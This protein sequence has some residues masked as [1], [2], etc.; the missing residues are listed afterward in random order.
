MTS[1][2]LATPDATFKAR[3]RDVKRPFVSPTAKLELVLSIPSSR[4]VTTHERLTQAPGAQPGDPVMLTS[5]M[6]GIREFT[7]N[8]QARSYELAFDRW[9]HTYLERIRTRMHRRSVRDALRVHDVGL[10][11]AGPILEFETKQ[12]GHALSVCNLDLFMRC[13]F[14]DDAETGLDWIETIDLTSHVSSE[15]G[16]EYEQPAGNFTDE[17]M[18]A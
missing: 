9:G 12:D 14:E 18:P 16:T 15:G 8:V 2:A 4:A 5:T 3:F 1:L 6:H 7:F 10:I 13:G 11:A 17:I